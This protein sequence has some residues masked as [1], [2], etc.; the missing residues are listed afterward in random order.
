VSPAASQCSARTGSEASVAFQLPGA[1]VQSESW[2]NTVAPR[3]RVRW[4]SSTIDSGVAAVAPVA[5][6]GGPQ[7][8]LQPG[9]PGPHKG[10]RR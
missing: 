10:R 3:T 1:D 6:P 9:P 7:H 2:S 4:T 8:R 5:A